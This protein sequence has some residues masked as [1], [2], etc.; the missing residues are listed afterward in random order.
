MRTPRRTTFLSQLLLTP[1]SITL[2]FSRQLEAA[3][4]GKLQ[5]L[6]RAHPRV[7][8]LRPHHPPRLFLSAVLSP[9]RFFPRFSPGRSLYFTST[10]NP[11]SKPTIEA[12][13]RRQAGLTVPSLTA[14]RFPLNP[15]FPLIFPSRNSVSTCPACPGK[16]LAIRISNRNEVKSLCRLHRNPVPVSE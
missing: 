12:K 5:T 6:N 7:R 9:S 3:G 16:L 4:G 14:E 2:F 15:R 13:K 8:R 11:A 10:P 1:T